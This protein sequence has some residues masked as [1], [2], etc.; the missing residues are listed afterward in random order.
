MVSESGT[1]VSYKTSIKIS[2]DNRSFFTDMYVQCT[3]EPK[4][5]KYGTTSGDI[6]L[7]CVILIEL[8]KREKKNSGCKNC[9]N[10]PS[11][12]SL[13]NS[14]LQMILVVFPGYYLSS[15]SPTYV[16]R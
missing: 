6:S 5:W 14:M 9:L 16:S 13:R 2:V 3:T 15:L 8:S 4:E 10:F 7:L 11:T 12:L 1:M